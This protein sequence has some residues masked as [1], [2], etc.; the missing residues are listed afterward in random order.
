MAAWLLPRLNP[1]G[2]LER[3]AV[4]KGE[5]EEANASKPVR[6]VPVGV[7]VLD[8]ANAPKPFKGAWILL[9]VF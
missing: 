6:F 1:V 8:D 2:D 5:D 9:W 7:D 4:A 3:A